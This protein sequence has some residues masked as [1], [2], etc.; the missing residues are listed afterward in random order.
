MGHL[1]H[2]VPLLLED[3]EEGAD[4][5]FAEGVGELPHDLHRRGPPEGVDDVENLAF[6]TAEAGFGGAGHG[7][8]ISGPLDRVG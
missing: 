2:E 8:M 5:A 4:G 3:P 6:A 7:A 1:V